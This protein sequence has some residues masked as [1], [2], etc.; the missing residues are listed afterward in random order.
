MT[1]LVS[2]VVPCH[3]YGRYL[4]EAVESVLAQ[5]VPLEL[6]VVDDGSTDDTL[7]IARALAEADPRVGVL[8][9][10]CSG[11]PAIARNNGI[12]RTTA[13][14]VLCL[15]ADDSI[16]PGFLRACVEVLESDP[17]VGIAYGDQQD[18]GGDLD[19]HVHAEY[20]FRLLTHQNF[21]GT[22]SVFRRAAWEAA[23]GYAT[24]V[25]GYE[26][27][28]FWVACGEH[29]F[30][31]LHVPAAIFDYRVSDTGLFSD[32]LDRDHALKAQMVLNHPRLYTSGEIAWARAVQAGITVPPTRTLVIPVIPPTRLFG[33]GRRVVAASAT[34]LARRPELLAAFAECALPD[35]TL[36]LHVDDPAALDAL[37]P[38]ADAV[39]VEVVAVTD[40]TEADVALQASAVLT[41]GWPGPLLSLLPRFVPLEA[42]A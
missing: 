12:A 41:E 1:P 11:Q 2:V 19:F 36:A 3:D 15:D 28:D 34:E 30:H 13:P 16:Q 17:S 35:S 38:H 42:A 32:A 21:I 27:W 10:P 29:G 6:L 40:A 22:A 23:G 14:Y 5:D 33:E 18:F 25:R 7:A 9:Q 26:D 8:A 24:N 4:R 39:P 20:D 37:A 31:G